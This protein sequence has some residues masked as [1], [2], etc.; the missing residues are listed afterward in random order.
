MCCLPGPASRPWATKKKRPN[1]FCAVHRCALVVGNAHTAHELRTRVESTGM[2]TRRALFP[3]RRHGHGRHRLPVP[4][5]GA[6]DRERFRTAKTNTT[7]A[8]TGLSN[9]AVGMAQGK[10][11]FPVMKLLNIFY[12]AIALTRR[13][14][15]HIKPRIGSTASPHLRPAVA[16]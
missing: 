15:H 2:G 4:F 13:T 8:L 7:N 5:H 11:S 12:V 16:C 6:A 10:T 9:L 1:P 3:T 14:S